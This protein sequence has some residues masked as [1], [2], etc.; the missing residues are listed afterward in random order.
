MHLLLYTKGLSAKI[1]RTTTPQSSRSRTQLDEGTPKT[2]GRKSSTTI[3]NLLESHGRSVRPLVCGTENA[4]SVHG[5]DEEGIDIWM[6]IDHPSTDSPCSNS[7]AVVL[8]TIA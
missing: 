1:F 7:A 8:S 2:G 6:I 4:W 3:L 5:E